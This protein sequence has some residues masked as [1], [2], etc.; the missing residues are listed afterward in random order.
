MNVLGR[1]GANLNCLGGNQRRA[2]ASIGS[3]PTTNSP[4]T[5]YYSLLSYV[6]LDL[7]FTDRTTVRSGSAPQLPR[8]LCKPWCLTR[9]ELLPMK[10]QGRDVGEKISVLVLLQIFC[11][12]RSLPLPSIMVRS[13]L[14]LQGAYVVV[15]KSFF[16]RLL[17][18][19]PWQSLPLPSI[20]VTSWPVHT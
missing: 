5:T 15:K 7:R 18:R 12:W 4:H 20:L 2:L 16:L 1:F 10:V 11:A 9:V 17:I 8:S 3:Y 13:W 19:C 14:L 6:T